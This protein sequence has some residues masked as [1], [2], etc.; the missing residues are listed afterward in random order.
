[1]KITE[2]S[3]RDYDQVLALWKSCSDEGVH[4]DDDGDSRKSIAAYLK[5]HSGMSFVAREKDRLIG[6]V[7]C[8]TDG[9]RGYLNHLAVDRAHRGKGIG[10]KL[11]ERSLAALK[12]TGINK[13]HIFVFK[14]NLA[15]QTF[16]AHNGWVMR[17][18]LVV[19]SHMPQTDACCG[20]K[21]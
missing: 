5:R 17:D 8:G 20:E 9:R 11:V 12:K 4:V 14:D 18:T 6:A 16:W 2:M 19:M 1:M 3:I 10:K 15:G 7:L 21:K 13:C